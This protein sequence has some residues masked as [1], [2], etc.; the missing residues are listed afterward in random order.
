MKPA[1][2]HTR[3]AAFTLVELLVVIAIIALL[4]GILL[5]VLGSAR[6]AARR[7]VCLSNVRQYGLS[8]TIYSNDH[9]ARAP[10]LYAPPGGT[11]GTPER[12][13][14]YY[15]WTNGVAGPIYPLYSGGYLGDGDTSSYFCPSES[16]KRWKFDSDINP[17]PPGTAGTDGVASTRLGYNV[18]PVAAWNGSPGGW[19]A[20]HKMP[21]L[22]EFASQAIAA[23]V[24]MNPLHL[25]QRH[26][27]GISAAMG[28][29]SARL[30][31]ESRFE[32]HLNTVPD[33]GAGPGNNDAFL[34]NFNSPSPVSPPTGMWADFSL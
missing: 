29:G 34:K 15:L 25:S 6:E 30:V 12:R 10:L 14:A 13:F 28:D 8:L 31:P 5:P 23:D 18:R 19:I 2:T 33:S 20:S 3:R 1:A 11:G 4:I 21:P 7:A 27:V 24:V 32:T 9:D 22:Y 26:A 16:N 17:W